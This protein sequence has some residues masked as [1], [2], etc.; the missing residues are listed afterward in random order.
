VNVWVNVEVYVVGVIHKMK[1]NFHSCT[2]NLDA[3][4][5]FIFPNWC[6][7]RLL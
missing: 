2:V 5:S 4:K 6:T 3:I 7:I 1:G